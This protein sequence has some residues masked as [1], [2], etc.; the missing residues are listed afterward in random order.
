MLRYK[1]QLRSIL[2]PK[3]LKGTINKT[4]NSM[5]NKMLKSIIRF[6]DLPPLLQISLYQY[7]YNPSRGQLVKSNQGF[8]FDEVLDLQVLLPKK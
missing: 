3:K 8:K 2:L 6:K 5:G 4:E 1:T 7:D